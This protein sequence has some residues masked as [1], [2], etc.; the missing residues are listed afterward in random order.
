MR[1]T[2]RIPCVTLASCAVA[3]VLWG[4]AQADAQTL[5]GSAAS[6]DRQNAQ[7]RAHSFTY[8]GT[9]EQV[10]RFVA[11]GYLVPV[12]SNGDF[13]VHQVSFPYARPEVR[14]FLERLAAQY[15]GACGEKLVVT[16]LTRPLSNQPRNASS[17][18]VH[19]TGMA[20]DLRRP[21]N[22]RCRSWLETTL[23]TLEG[24]GVLEAIYER[25]PPHYHVA[26]FPQPYREY[27]AQRVGAQTVAALL[28]EAPAGVDV[29]WI[30][31]RVARGENLTAIAGRYGA[32]VS[33]IR[34]ENG[35]QGSRI[36]A[37]QDL[38]IPIYSD[39]PVAGATVARAASE[40]TTAP[41]RSVEA[42]GAAVAGPS[43]GGEAEGASAPAGRSA[44]ALVH[45]VGRGDSL[46]SISRLYG[47]SEAQL[48]RANGIDGSRILVGQRLQVPGVSQ[49]AASVVQHRVN[50]GDSLW[51]I[52]RR[53]GVSVEDIRRQNG[54]G[55]RIYAGQI[56]EIPVDG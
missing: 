34:A 2:A 15:H 44:A 30:T 3:A 39:A 24:N 41:V 47:V 21:Q 36:F 16:S 22:A 32:A 17:R 35:I 6:L 19:P 9:P 12:V 31:H 10:R 43:D 28:D 45:T 40:A 54:I 33:R 42:S 25:T 18:S 4:A 46:W 53:H 38:R 29:R 11:E 27:L 14:L 7:A 55:T 13:D 48:R 52:A 1:P 50:R 23:L 49:D 5:R 51:S 56:L 37:G 26:L 20:F 8:L